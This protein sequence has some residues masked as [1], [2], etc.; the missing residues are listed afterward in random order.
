MGRRELRPVVM[1]VVIAVLVM[2]ALAPVASAAPP[3]SGG[4]YWYCVVPGDSWYRV[5]QKT[6]VS[7]WALKNANPSHHHWCDWLYVGHCLWIPQY[8]PP[9]EP[10]GACSPCGCSYWYQVVTGDTW[11]AVSRK[12]GRSYATLW[13]AN[14]AHHHWNNWLYTG[15]RLCIP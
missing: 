7:V 12:T 15:H 2:L 8:Q 4:G 13:R 6:G 14:P 10:C 1:A 3:L 11:Y 9:C 5:S